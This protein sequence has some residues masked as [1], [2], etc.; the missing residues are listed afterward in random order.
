MPRVRGNL[1]Y[2][3][4]GEKVSKSGA[5]LAGA[6]LCRKSLKRD[7]WYARKRPSFPA[8]YRSAIDRTGADSRYTSVKTRQCFMRHHVQNFG[9][10]AF[11]DH[12]GAE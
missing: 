8:P 3:Q 2:L 4:N 5:E 7:A 12:W 11:R 1:A 9:G 10:V 6:G